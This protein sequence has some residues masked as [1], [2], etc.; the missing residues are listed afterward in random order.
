MEVGPGEGRDLLKGFSPQ[1]LKSNYIRQA[2]EL[3][4][5]VGELCSTLA[6]LVLWSP[7]AGGSGLRNQHL[8]H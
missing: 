6:I 8:L 1:A 3:W 7:E 2:V 4:K 5:S